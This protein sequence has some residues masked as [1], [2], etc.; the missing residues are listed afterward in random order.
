[1]DGGG[2]EQGRERG[3]ARGTEGE[4]RE[5]RVILVKR[6]MPCRRRA[7]ACVFILVLEREREDCLQK[8]CWWCRFGE[9]SVHDVCERV[10]SR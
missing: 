7:G 1:M 9:F 3:N 6:V 8:Q 2:Q 5:E 10:G 4:E